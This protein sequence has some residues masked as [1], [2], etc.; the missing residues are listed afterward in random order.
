MTLYTACPLQVLQVTN[1]DTQKSHHLCPHCFKNPPPD[2]DAAQQGEMRCFKCT[3][4]CPLASVKE[5]PVRPC[6]K[7]GQPVRPSRCRRFSAQT[8]VRAEAS[9]VHVQMVL[10]KNKDGSFRLGCKGYPSCKEVIWLPKA[11][12]RV[13]VESDDCGCGSKRLCFEFK[14]RPHPFRVCLIHELQT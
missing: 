5:S 12:T 8:R 1:T 2:A 3:H 9:V 13:E 11:A 10:K 6:A 7:C 14:V 4:N